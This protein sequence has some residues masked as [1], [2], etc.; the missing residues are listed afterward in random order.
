VW[1]IRT[2][3]QFKE[4]TKEFQLKVYF[5]VNPVTIFPAEI[6]VMLDFI[7]AVAVWSRQ[8]IT[9]IT[10]FGTACASTA[11]VLNISPASIPSLHPL[12]I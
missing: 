1:K 11:M 3:N 9:C 12:S 2:G 8:L 10:P 7:I 5:F 6:G 4:Y